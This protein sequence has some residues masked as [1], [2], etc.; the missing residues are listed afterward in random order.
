MSR[1][2]LKLKKCSD[3]PNPPNVG[4]ASEEVAVKYDA[5]ALVKRC[6]RR[7]SSVVPHRRKERPR[8]TQQLSTRETTIVTTG[9]GTVPV[10]PAK[11]IDCWG[12]TPPYKCQ[13]EAAKILDCLA[14]K[15]DPRVNVN[16]PN[17]ELTTEELTANAEAIISKE[18]I[19]FDPKIAIHRLEDGYRVFCDS[20]SNAPPT[21][22]LDPLEG[23]DEP[24]DEI[25]FIGNFTE[26]NDDTKHLSAGNIWYSPEDARNSPVRVSNHLASKEAGAA[27]AI[28][29]AIQNSPREVSLHFRIQSKRILHSLTKGLEEYENR[30]WL[31]IADSILLRAITAAL[32]GRGT[33]CFLREAGELDRN[34]MS[35]ADEL[36]K[37]GMVND[38]PAPLSTDMIYPTTL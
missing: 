4:S 23:E 19:I 31:G 26:V 5:L 10:I 25:V 30:G 3:K 32:G 7:T 22:Q 17:P 2:N 34:D 20:R 27:A 14:E 21:H 6:Q 1:T 29:Y 33:R 38:P 18:D 13:G 24:S 16:Q 15:W 9:D 28:L 11:Q 12:T 8:P 35:K 36:A 37:I